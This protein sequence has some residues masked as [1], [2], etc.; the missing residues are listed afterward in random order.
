VHFERGRD[1]TRAIHYL[2]QASQNAMRRN[3]YQEAISLLTKGLELLKLRPDTPERPQQELR[4]QIALGSTLMAT[5]GYAAPEVGKA[6]TRARELCQKVSETKQLLPVLVGLATFSLVRAELQITYELMEQF[7]R[8][9]QKGQ[10][11][12]DL[13]VGHYVIGEVLFHWG[14]LTKAQL[15]LE[16]GL[17]VYDLQ[18]RSSSAWNDPRVACLC[19]A[20]Y[21]LWSLGYPDQALRRCHESLTLAQEL[22]HPFSLAFAL[23]GTTRLHQFRREVEATREH[24][25]TLITISTEQGFA[26]RAATGNI[27]QGWAL[28]EQGQGEEGVKQ[29]RQG[30]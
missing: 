24:A 8:L 6:Y 27:L 25:E 29:I 28:A 21:A 11:S 30:L 7:L 4:L 1:I 10:N 2:E 12:A 16:Q 17:T 19:I 18:R 22:S 26:L 3:A 15:H 14:E 13:Q 20:A 5:K 9:S 23:Y